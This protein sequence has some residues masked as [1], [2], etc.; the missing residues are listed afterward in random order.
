MELMDDLIKE[1]RDTGAMLMTYPPKPDAK[2]RAATAI[3]SLCIALSDAADALEHA[4]N[5]LGPNTNQIIG[6]EA[7]H[8]RAR[9]ALD[10]ADYGWH[11]IPDTPEQLLLIAKHNAMMRRLYPNLVLIQDVDQEDIK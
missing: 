1:L 10:E 11:E 3:E 6:R 7:A 8:L 2:L 5:L 9:I 4:N